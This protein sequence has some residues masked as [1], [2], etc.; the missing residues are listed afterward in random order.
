MQRRLRYLRI[1]L[2][3]ERGEL[4][5]NHTSHPGPYIL[6]LSQ[7]TLSLRYL[8]SW[9]RCAEQGSSNGPQLPKTEHGQALETSLGV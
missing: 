3:A 5:C 6:Y 9:G 1:R 2:E 4:L 7:T 8:L